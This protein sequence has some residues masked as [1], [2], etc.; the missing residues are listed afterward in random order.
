MTLQYTRPAVTPKRPISTKPLDPLRCRA[1]S[2]FV[3][4]LDTVLLQST[5]PPTDLLGCIEGVRLGV[6]PEWVGVGWVGA[7]WVG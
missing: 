1:S 2:F 3:C 6:V 5:D 7:G 4:F